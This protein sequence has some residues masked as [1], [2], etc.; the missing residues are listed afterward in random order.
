MPAREA[1]RAYIS[2]RRCQH[3]PWRI[4]DLECRLDRGSHSGSQTSRPAPYLDGLTRPLAAKSERHGRAGRPLRTP[5]R[6][7][8]I[9]RLGVRIPPDA[10]VFPLV[11]IHMPSSSGLPDWPNKPVD[12]NAAMQLSLAEQ[13]RVL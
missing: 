10:P 12:S 4:E 11:S 9:R 1:V 2:A 8:R 13:R 5:D 6:D 7:L 3:E